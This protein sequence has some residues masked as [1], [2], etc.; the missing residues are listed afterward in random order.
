MEKPKGHKQN[1]LERYR[2]EIE[3]MRARGFSF[4][5]IADWLQDK[6]LI[7]SKS[8]VRLFLQ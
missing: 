5:Q 6:G 8:T 1:L 4:Q 2:A 7:V 3:E